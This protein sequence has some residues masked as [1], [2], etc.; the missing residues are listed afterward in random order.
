[1]RDIDI[2]YIAGLFDG[3]GHVTIADTKTGISL[4]AA[5][6][7]NNIL[8]LQWIIDS[9]GM[10]CL[11]KESQKYLKNTNIIKLDCY[12]LHLTGYEAGLFLTMIEP[13]IRIKKKQVNIGIEF[14]KTYI[15]RLNLGKKITQEIK[16]KRML[17]RNEVL[18]LNKSKGR[19]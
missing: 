19:V 1:M 14:A 2:A 5:I 4:R 16:E 17:Y 13:Y 8:I 10:G 11:Y 15:R 18:E 7:N 6:S 12:R 9:I 3:E